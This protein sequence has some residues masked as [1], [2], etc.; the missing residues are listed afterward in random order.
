MSPIR[1]I[2]AWVGL[3]LAGALGACS[4]AEVPQD[5]FYRLVASPPE[6]VAAG[7]ARDITIAVERPDADG[8]VAGRPIVYAEDPR[9]N[10]LFAYNYH[11]WAE[12]PAIM[13]RD[14]LVAC[15][16]AAGVAREVVTE[17]LRV[18]AARSVAGKV[19]RLEQVL[20]ASA[21]VVVEIELGVR[22]T[23]R[24]RLLHLE[25][26]VAEATAADSGVAAAADAFNRAFSDLC[27]R[28]AADLARL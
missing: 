27:A 12:P 19:H 17:E 7:P 6:P 3:A 4:P 13:L 9:P 26:Y 25:T 11:F 14:E 5:R 15:L 8:L 21:R 20:G 2:S 23:R 10:E 16:R 24:G 18:G 22:D 1:P 28:C